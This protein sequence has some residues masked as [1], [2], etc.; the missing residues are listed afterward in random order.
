MVSIET[1]KSDTFYGDCMV[2]LVWRLSGIFRERTRE[3][4]LLLIIIV[5]AR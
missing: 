4:K 2:K 5:K 1:V 3:I